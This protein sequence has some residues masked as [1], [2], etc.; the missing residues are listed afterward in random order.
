MYRLFVWVACGVSEFRVQATGRT[1]QWQMASGKLWTFSMFDWQHA[2]A[3]NCCFCSPQVKIKTRITAPRPAQPWKDG[4]QDRK[5]PKDTSILIALA[6]FG[7][8]ER[9]IIVPYLKSWATTWIGAVWVKSDWNRV[10]TSCHSLHLGS[11][12]SGP[13]GHT[14]SNRIAGAGLRS[15]V[16]HLRCSIMLHMQHSGTFGSELRKV[17]WKAWSM[18]KVGLRGTRG[19]QLAVA[20]FFLWGFTDG[21]LEKWRNGVVMIGLHPSKISKGILSPCAFTPKTGICLTK[22]ATL[23]VLTCQGR[24]APSVPLAEYER[25]FW[26]AARP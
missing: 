3:C 20:C 5:S 18:K 24:T 21:E 22:N 6:L 8:V 1:F 4:Y 17:R 15:S 7:E 14:S 16:L 19:W 12:C 10:K 13:H 9:W 11:R 26:M 2:I 23:P 25:R